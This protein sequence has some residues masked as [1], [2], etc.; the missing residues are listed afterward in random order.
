MVKIMRC[1]ML[2]VVLLLVALLAGC[3]RAHIKVVDQ[4]GEP[5]EGVLVRQSFY[6]PSWIPLTFPGNRGSTEI[7]TK[8]TDAKGRL[9]LPV[10][11]SGFPVNITHVEKSGYQF[12]AFEQIK[13]DYWGRRG[14]GIR[15][16][17]YEFPY[18]TPLVIQG[19]KR[20]EQAELT[21]VSAYVSI[22]R[23]LETC[24]LKMDKKYPPSLDWWDQ[25][26]RRKEHVLFDPPVIIKIQQGTE[27]KEFT[28]GSNSVQQSKIPVWRAQLSVQGAKIQETDDLF[29][30]LAPESGYHHETVLSKGSEATTLSGFSGARVF[31]VFVRSEDGSFYGGGMFLFSPDSRGVA[32]FL[33]FNFNGSRNIMRHPSET[34]WKLGQQPGRNPKPKQTYG[35]GVQC[36][37]LEEQ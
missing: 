16:D 7:I 26:R 15:P 33:W 18:D 21:Y 4:Y 23:T 36:Q 32:F 11:W 37:E 31:Q 28:H 1:L 8:H 30:N 5:I 29:M 10:D 2:P 3:S 19:W 34:F 22:P 24:T 13:R 20:E 9:T 17:E 25:Q 14:T 6:H 35:Y 12:R 27:I